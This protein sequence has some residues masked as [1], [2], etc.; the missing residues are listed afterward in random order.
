MK[1][2]HIEVINMH[3]IKHLINGKWRDG[4]NHVTTYSPTDLSPF[5]KAPIGDASEVDEA[6][7]AANVAFQRWRT[8]SCADRAAKVK[9]L[10]G[11]L[12]K[13][14]GEANVATPLKQCIVDE[15]GK[16]LPE[17]D[18]EVLEC[19]D[20][21]EFFIQAASNVFEPKEVKINASLWPT[22][23]S[24]VIREPIGV[25]GII[26]P[27]NY[28]IEM[29][30]WSLAPAIIAGNAVV[31]KPSEKAPVSNFMLAELISQTDI[32]PGVVNFV[33]GDRNTG[34]E[35]VKHPGVRM[36]S[37]TGSVA[38][39]RDVATECGKQLKKAS[40]ELGGND[41]AIVMDDVDI[42]LAANGLV[43][44]AFCNAG[45]VCVGVKRAYV[46]SRIYN[47]IVDAVL[48]KTNLLMAGRD[49]GPIIDAKQLESVRQFIQQAK[50]S[51]N[52]ILFGGE[53]GK[54]GT[55]LEP[56][57]IE[58]SNRKA[59]L[60]NSEC[61][62]PVLPLIKYETLDDAI[63]E[64]NNSE[65]GLGASVWG[66]DLTK[67]RQVAERLK[68][69]MVWINDVNVAFPEAP[70]GGVKDSGIGF[71]LSEEALKEYS[72]IKHIN[73]ETSRETRR[74]WWYPYG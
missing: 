33:F 44:G 26:K 25:V 72:T 61:F 51:G 41:A 50:M 46:P 27:W 74:F 42:E 53:V 18:V 60:L 43:W 63:N 16:P 23:T 37:F 32:P 19:G 49:I 11:E 12:R 65:Y 9:T 35:I 62:G 3:E 54:T 45:Q 71:E 22:K 47:K 73:T 36:I 17:A 66:T 20:F 31:V 69:G 56:T 15:V 59:D 70:W 5:A 10:V 55:Y 13:A 34:R 57:V 14:Y 7:A 67:A 40:L 28:P 52:K 58:I 4:S 2:S 38:A 68:A 24:S 29:V 6:V 21:T 8:L 30:M 39:G 64:A 48:S 1:R